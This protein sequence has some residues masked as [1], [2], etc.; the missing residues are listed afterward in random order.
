MSATAHAATLGAEDFVLLTPFHDTVVIV[1]PQ[2]QR[3]DREDA[4]HG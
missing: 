4:H 3:A 2:P 1:T